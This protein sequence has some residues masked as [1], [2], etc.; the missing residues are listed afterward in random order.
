MAH[1]FSIELSSDY[2]DRGR[3]DVKMSCELA[4]EAGARIGFVTAGGGDG[5]GV[6][7]A[8]GV[9]LETGPCSGVRVFVYVIP[10]Q[11]PEQRRVSTKYDFQMALCVRCDGKTVRK[12]TV[13][14]NKWGG[15][16]VER[17]YDSSGQVK[18]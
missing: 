4:D 8:G 6:S 2:E 3:Y 1:R 9:K 17:A 16:S 15:A 14:V 13:D 5:G 7:L 10:R 12:E 11:L 18:G